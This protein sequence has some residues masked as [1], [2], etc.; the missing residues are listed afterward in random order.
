[1]FRLSIAISVTALLLT[2]GF[3]QADEASLALLR[4]QAMSHSAATEPVERPRLAAQVIVECPD[5]AEVTFD[6]Q[7][8]WSTGGVR[9]F[10]TNGFGTYTVRCSTGNWV[11]ERRV[12]VWPGRRVTIR[13]SGP[14]AAGAGPYLPLALSGPQALTWGREMA[15][16]GPGFGG[17]FGG[18]GG[19]S[20]GGC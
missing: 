7:R 16:P 6:G 9:R 4:L 11:E 17:G 1:M 3:A 20:G 10:M 14:Q 5:G 2:C 13:F 18:W 15:F 19:G 12:R 8:T